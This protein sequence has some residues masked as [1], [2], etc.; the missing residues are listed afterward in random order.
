MLFDLLVWCMPHLL[1]VSSHC[2]HCWL[3][4]ILASRRKN[5][6]LTSHSRFYFGLDFLYHVRWWMSIF[7]V[8]WYH[9]SIVSAMQIFRQFL[10]NYNCIEIEQDFLKKNHFGIHNTHSM[11]S[12]Y[13][14]SRIFL[15]LYM[16][17]MA[18]Y[19]SLCTV[20]GVFRLVIAFCGYCVT[21]YLT[22]FHSSSA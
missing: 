13:F 19:C 1:S 11:F 18:F 17:F 4:G 21:L 5:A 7:S 12:L 22:P 20:L 16:G 6:Q 3:K 9:I 10:S 8:E 2:P 15:Q 14:L